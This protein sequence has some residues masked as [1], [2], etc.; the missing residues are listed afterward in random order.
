ML[1]VSIA[2]INSSHATDNSYGVELVVE[3]RGG[4]DPKTAFD[5]VDTNGFPLYMS[6]LTDRR[7]G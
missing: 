7:G 4:G 6:C 3:V 5:N 1:V 2:P